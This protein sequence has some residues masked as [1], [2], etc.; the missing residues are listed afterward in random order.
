[1]AFS[2]DPMPVEGAYDFCEWT[3]RLYDGLNQLQA[4]GSIN[5][6]PGY[7]ELRQLYNRLDD[8]IRSAADEAQRK[9]EKTMVVT[10]EFTPQEARKFSTLGE[11]VMS[12]IE[13]LTTRGKLD[14]APSPAAI[15]AIAALRNII[16]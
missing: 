10:V 14:G 4:D 1:M 5:P 2:S 6:I 9:G 12:Y 8:A 15:E 7:A 16:S 3:G 11:S 13:I